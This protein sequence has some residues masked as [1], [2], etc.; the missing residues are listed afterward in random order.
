M[1]LFCRD[2]MRKDLGIALAEAK[3]NGAQLPV[4]ELVDG[5]LCGSAGDGGWTL[6]YIQSA[7][8]LHA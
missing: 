1:S 2:W 7:N 3:N 8:A 4:A 5:F 6:G